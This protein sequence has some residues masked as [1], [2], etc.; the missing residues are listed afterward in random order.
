VRGNT[1]Q[2]VTHLHDDT[3][4]GDLTAEDLR[5]VGEREES[6]FEGRTDLATVDVKRSDDLDVVDPVATQFRVHDPERLVGGTTP[7]P[8]GVPGKALNEGTGAI[9]DTGDGN[10]DAA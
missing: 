7:A 1:V 2:H 9:P 8:R 3:A 10:S 6:L 4:L 5:V